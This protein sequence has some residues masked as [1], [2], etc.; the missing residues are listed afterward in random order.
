MRSGCIQDTLSSRAAL[1]LPAAFR[2]SASREQ[3]YLAYKRS[4]IP[5]CALKGDA[6]CIN[7]ESRPNYEIIFQYLLKL[8]VF[9]IMI[10]IKFNFNIFK[11]NNEYNKILLFRTITHNN[12]YSRCHVLLASSASG[13]ARVGET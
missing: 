3:R 6:T 10:T 13:L 8:N 5:A 12:G 9:R 1:G 2:P 11:M 4:G 7:V